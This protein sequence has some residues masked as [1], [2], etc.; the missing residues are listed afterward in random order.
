MNPGNSF[1][2]TSLHILASQKKVKLLSKFLEVVFNHDHAESSHILIHH[3]LIGFNLNQEESTHR[4]F[5]HVLL[6]KGLITAFEEISRLY[7][8]VLDLKG[9]DMFQNST[10]VSYFY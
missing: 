9:R 3:S 10:L 2:Q 6:E 7:S 5:M 4:T 8:S 1:K